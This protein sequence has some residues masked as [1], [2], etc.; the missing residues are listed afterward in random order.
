MR[1]IHR[2][3]HAGHIAGDTGGGFIVGDEHDL[4][5]MRLVGLELLGKNFD[6]NAL[7][8]RHIDHVDLEAHALAHVSPQQRELAEAGDQHLVAGRQRVGHGGFPAAGAR[9]REQEDLRHFGLEDL[10]HVGA[11]RQGDGGT[12][13]RTLVFQ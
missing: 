12:I 1:A 13:R 3:A 4:V 8:P 6:G 10:L 2:L 9:C 5:G 11:E 7:A